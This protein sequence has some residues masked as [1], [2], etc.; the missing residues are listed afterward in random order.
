MIT[1]DVPADLNFEDDDGFILA[2]IP[3][4]GAPRVGQALVAGGPGGWTWA[5]VHDVEAGWV[6]LRP[7]TAREAASYNPL[8]AG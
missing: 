8:V 4:T 6:R 5:V 3:D 7:V 2:R 1:V